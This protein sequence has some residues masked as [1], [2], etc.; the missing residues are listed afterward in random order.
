MY[1]QDCG[2]KLQTSVCSKCGASAKREKIPIFVQQRGTSISGVVEAFGFVILVAVLV[3]G[4][5]FA[6]NYWKSQQTAFGLEVK[7]DGEI[8]LTIP[9]S[10]SLIRETKIQHLKNENPTTTHD[11]SENLNTNE[12]IVPKLTYRPRKNATALIDRTVA[13]P[14]LK[15]YYQE[16]NVIDS[17][18]VSGIFVAKGG[19]NDIQA[20]L[21]DQ[22]GFED[23]KS[24]LKFG[25]Y[26]KSDGY[27]TSQLIDVN[28]Q[29]GKYILIFDNRKALL[30]RKEVKI[31]IEAAIK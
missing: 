25:A 9:S 2:T 12:N 19:N 28:L 8:N 3:V 7:K 5:I 6:F 23:F 29:P 27:V 30:T 11:V 1:C 4:G 21:V 18:T 31:Y 17:S 14:G 26:F 20:F 22:F 15:Y 24:G 10:E 16:F 13:V